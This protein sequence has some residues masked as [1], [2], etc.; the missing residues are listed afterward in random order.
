[1][2]RG[3]R[4]YVD[5]KACQTVL[6]RKSFHLTNS[7]QAPRPDLISKG[8]LSQAAPLC[9]AVPG[10]LGGDNWFGCPFHPSGDRKLS[11]TLNAM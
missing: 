9:S 3:A 5:F 8:L 7:Q 6:S 2:L 4:R 1:M 11:I 10:A